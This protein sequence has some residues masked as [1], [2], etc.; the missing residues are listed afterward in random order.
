MSMESFTTNTFPA[1][2]LD[3]DKPVLVDFWAPW[4]GPC[5]ALAPVLAEISEEHG[6]SDRT[7]DTSVARRWRRATKISPVWC[8][9]S[10]V[11]GSG[12]GRDENVAA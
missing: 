7:R 3:Q 5:K 6:D 2:V 4:C 8:N 1:D 9:G 11:F 10:M 12:D